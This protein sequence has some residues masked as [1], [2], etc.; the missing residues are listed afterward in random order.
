MRNSPVG[1]KPTVPFRNLVAPAKEASLHL[2]V[3]GINRYQNSAL[4]LNF[5]APDADGIVAYFRQNGAQLFRDVN[6]VQLRDAEATKANILAAFLKIREKAH[7]QDVVICYFAGHSD[8]RG[9]QW[10]FI[11]HDMTRPESDEEVTSK[12]LSSSTISDEVVRIKAQKMLLLVD[13]CKSGSL[14]VAFRGYE[15]RKVMAQLARA[16]GIHIIAA[17]TKDQVASEVKELGHGVFTYLLLKGLGGEAVTKA[18]DRSVTVRGLL[19]YIETQL[20]EIS[21][22]YKTRVQYPVSVS[23]GMD[24]PLS[25]VK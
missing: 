6:I 24:F 20:P 4:N 25:L 1:Y 12:G 23:T 5:A 9:D 19:A 22:K 2:L 10:Y 11:P 18:S 15:D 7:P 21:M 3:V 16:T 14:L 13:A 8:N 17:S